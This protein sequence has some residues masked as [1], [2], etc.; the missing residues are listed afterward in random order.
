MRKIIEILLPILIVF[1]YLKVLSFSGVTSILMIRR[2]SMAKPLSIVFINDFIDCLAI[3]FIALTIS[4]LL[5]YECRKYPSFLL[6][7]A[8]AISIIF[9]AS[10]LYFCSALTSL[11]VGLF[12]TIYAASLKKEIRLSHL[13]RYLFSLLLLIEAVGV[14]GWLLYLLHGGIN[15]YMEPLPLQDL[16]TKIIYSFSP[17][18]PV[19]ATLFMLSIPL[20]II[21]KPLRPIE[22]SRPA[23]LLNRFKAF[24]K[25]AVSN[26]SRHS[27]KYGAWSR[28]FL[29][30][31]LIIPALATFLLYTPAVNPSNMVIGVDILYYVDFLRD[32]QG[33]S[34]NGLEFLYKVF[35]SDRS[36]T[37]L[38]IYSISRLF[39]IDFRL[40]S[41]YLPA[42]L[43]PFLILSLYYLTLNLFRN[44][45]CASLAC[46][47]AATG[48]FTTASFY[49]GFLANWLGLS[50]T[51]LSLNIMMKSIEQYSMKALLLS[52]LLSILSHLAHPVSWSFLM[53][54]I[55]L[56]ALLVTAQRNTGR[57][58]L[59]FLA[60]FIAVNILYDFIKTRILKFTGATVVAESIV[61]TELS[62]ANLVNFWP[63]NVFMA[64]FHVGGAFNFPPTYI[65]A[66]LGMAVFSIARFLKFDILRM[67][68]LAGLPLYLLGPDYVQARTLQNIPIDIFA[69]GGL[70]MVLEYLSL[71]DKILS[72]LLLIFIYLLY[73]NNLLRFIV[74]LP[75]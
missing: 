43:S 33:S 51:Y 65:F 4:I 6:I 52:I 9:L 67:W 71:K 3:A 73:L 7:L 29:F 27:E 32:L 20:F 15:P 30:S 50:L 39:A 46:F 68:V 69:S 24:T 41:I 8:S 64:Y 70:V 72:A 35:S 61:S 42:I 28:I 11:F 2:W 31:A 55:T 53:A 34:Q 45:L 18:T 48:P 12:S 49:G 40:A 38:I 62:F 10:S 37:L 66:L 21:V 14:I 47:L 22:G 58:I 26:L 74:N 44:K 16:E 1:S 54:A 60:A 25:N 36:L 13:A 75:F 63:I 23:E 19:L 17:L 57:G 59:K 5:A 56:T